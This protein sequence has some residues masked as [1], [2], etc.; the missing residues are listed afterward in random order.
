MLENVLINAEASGEM[1]RGVVGEAG[2]GREE[3]FLT[4]VV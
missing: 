1:G 2:P 4:D 3:C